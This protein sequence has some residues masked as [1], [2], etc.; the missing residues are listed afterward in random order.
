MMFA[1]KMNG[2][3]TEMNEF[4][5]IIQLLIVHFTEVLNNKH[6]TENDTSPSPKHFHDAICWEWGKQS[7]GSVPSLTNVHILLIKPCVVILSKQ[8]GMHIKAPKLCH[9]NLI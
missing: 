7:M 8:A 2:R 5:R 9:K 1:T 4:V 3:F 6:C